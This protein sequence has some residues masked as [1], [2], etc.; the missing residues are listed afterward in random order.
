MFSHKIYI[1]THLKTSVQSEHEMNWISDISA[2][3]QWNRVDTLV[4]HHFPATCGTVTRER[5]ICP[6]EAAH[7]R[8]YVWPVTL[9]TTL[10]THVDCIDIKCVTIW[11]GNF[12]ADMARARYSSCDVHNVISPLRPGPVHAWWLGPRR[13]Y[14]EMF[15][16]FRAYKYWWHRGQVA[17]TRVYIKV[18]HAPRQ[19]QPVENS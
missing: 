10:Q 1:S 18:T 4:K 6:R 5:I 3:Q 19:S 16:L 11:S 14:R 8:Q 17:L 2:N 9:K 7:H 13:G 12:G 15:V